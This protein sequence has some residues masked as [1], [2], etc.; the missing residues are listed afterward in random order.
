M[1]TLDARSNAAP[2]RAVRVLGR[3]AGR[4]S[5]AS[6][7]L[8][9]SW[10]WSRR[11]AARTLSD[12]CRGDVEIELVLAIRPERPS[13]GSIPP[14][15]TIEAVAEWRL[16]CEGREIVGDAQVSRRR[17]LRGERLDTPGFLHLDL[18]DE[19][20]VFLRASLST[21]GC[22]ANAVWTRLPD[23]LAVAGGC[24]SA[25]AID[26]EEGDDPSPPS[27]STAASANGYHSLR[28]ASPAVDHASASAHPS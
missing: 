2:H 24:L 14:V 11:A 25:P 18:S 6:C 4:P 19:R 12:E 20:G 28:P 13:L 9:V 15:E 8:R 10:T 26:F 5:Q 23:E 7:T 17:S 16:L 3:S 22:D 21:E 27:R 1:S